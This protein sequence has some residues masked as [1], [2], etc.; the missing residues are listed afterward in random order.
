MQ[1]KGA[2][3]GNKSNYEAFV[4]VECWRPR[5]SPKQAHFSR[6]EG[7]RDGELHREL[8]QLI[9]SSEPPTLSPSEFPVLFKII[10]VL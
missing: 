8:I 5:V 4:M 6:A 10:L 2:I 9:T 3:A 1:L 7:D